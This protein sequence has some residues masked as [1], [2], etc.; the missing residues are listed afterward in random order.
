MATSA[1]DI[2]DAIDAAILVMMTGGGAQTISVAGRS[3]TYNDLDSLLQARQ[4]YARIADAAVSNKLPFKI[5][6]IKPKG[7]GQS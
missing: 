4:V 7:T 6:D 5:I 3:V 2:R 1:A